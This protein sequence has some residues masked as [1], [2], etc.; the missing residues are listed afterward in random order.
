M[1]APADIFNARILIVDDQDSNILLLDRTLRGAGYTNILSCKDPNTVCDLHRTQRF[2]LI[3]LDIEMSGQSFS[4]FQVMEALA[5]MEPDALLPV[6]VIS[7]HPGH[8]LNALQAGARDFISNPYE[9]AE[10]LARV[11]NMLEVRLLQQAAVQRIAALEERLRQTGQQRS[12]DSGDTAQRDD[13][14]FVPH[15]PRAA[16]MH[17][18]L[19]IEDEPDSIKLVEQIVA[20]IPDVLMQSALDGKVGIDIARATLPDVILLDINLP[21]INGFELLNMLRADPAT[22]AIPVI[23]ISANAMPRIIEKSKQVG[24]IRYLTKP[25]RIDEFMSAVDEALACAPPAAVQN[26]NPP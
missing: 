7:A 23:A 5:K 26:S 13:A 1:T 16:R 6:I 3:L 4:G 9:L 12:P 15:T 18:L 21:D 24:F 2:D 10:L 17:N 8:M 19:Y 22:C 20:R 25:F 11:H 14:M